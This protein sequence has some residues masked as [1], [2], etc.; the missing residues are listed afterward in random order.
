MAKTA[1]KPS[2]TSAKVEK[3]S[4]NGHATNETVADHRHPV[5][6]QQREQVAHSVGVATEAVVG[7]RRI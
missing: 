7:A 1:T 6:L 4:L 5:D 2:S 3:P